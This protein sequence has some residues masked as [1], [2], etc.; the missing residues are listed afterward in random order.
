VCSVCSGGFPKPPA[1]SSNPQPP[2]HLPLKLTSIHCDIKNQTQ[3]CFLPSSDSSTQSGL[4]HSYSASQQ[5]R[6]PQQT[7]S[8]YKATARVTPNDPSILVEIKTDLKQSHLFLPAPPG[9]TLCINSVMHSMHISHHLLQCKPHT[10]K[11]Q[12]K[13]HKTH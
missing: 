1:W 6:L 12:L 2:S 5:Q 8:T 11:T 9:I 10:D 7:L 3:E 13:E 4:H